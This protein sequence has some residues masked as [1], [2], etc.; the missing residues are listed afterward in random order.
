MGLGS[1]SKNA[2]VAPGSRRRRFFEKFRVS[3]RELLAR[4]L[5]ALRGLTAIGI[6]V[7]GCL[8]LWNEAA[9]FDYLTLGAT[10]RN[11]TLLLH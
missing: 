6:F 11:R 9:F 8:I 2:A 3:L 7:D 5:D 10:D 4:L 1:C